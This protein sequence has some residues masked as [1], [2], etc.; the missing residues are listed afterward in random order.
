MIK[1]AVAKYYE[2]LRAQKDIEIKSEIEDLDED[3]FENDFEDV[4]V[5]EISDFSNDYLE[6]KFQKNTNGINND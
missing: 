5:L 2:K 4:N 3:A 1:V 6:Q